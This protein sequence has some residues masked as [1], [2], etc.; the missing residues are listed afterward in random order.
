MVSHWIVE[1]IL[2]SHYRG[3]RC[4][5]IGD[6][7]H[8]HPPTTG[9]GLKSGIQDAHNLAWK[10]AALVRGRAGDRLLDS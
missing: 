1:S 6:A 8:R 7:A 3:G 2:A 4:V 5:V 9:L 10:P